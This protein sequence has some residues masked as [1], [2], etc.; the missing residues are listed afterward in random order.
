MQGARIAE[1]NH[2]DAIRRVNALLMTSAVLQEQKD[3]GK[4]E[5]DLWPVEQKRLPSEVH[6]GPADAGD[7][8][9]AHTGAVQRNTC[10]EPSSQRCVLNGTSTFHK[11]WLG[12]LHVSVAV[13]YCMAAH[14]G[15]GPDPTEIGQDQNPTS[16]AS[17]EEHGLQIIDQPC[18]QY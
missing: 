18:R 11:Y 8:T 9:A 2:L 16:S 4:E 12:C 13:Q 7:N 17:S 1:T 3:K 14:A 5:G 6:H 15:A 10:F